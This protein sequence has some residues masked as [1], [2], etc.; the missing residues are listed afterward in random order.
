MFQAF[1][2]FRAV[3]VITFGIVAPVALFVAL[4]VSPG[5]AHAQAGNVY[6]SNQTQV[7]GGVEQ[8]VVLQVSIKQVE[9]SAQSRVAGGAIGA[10]VGGALAS[11]P[12]IDASKRVMANILGVA[13]G[14]LAGERIANASSGKE[15]QEMIIKLVDQQG[16][17]RLITVV[18]P[19]P[20]DPMFKGDKVFVSNTQ[21]AVRVIKDESSL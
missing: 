12:N 6:G 3:D 7:Y 17:A 10:A 15:A 2:T 1:K 11:N 14:G 19:E 4:F 20:F 16:R 13:L 9:A 21:G 8:G 18:Q 5:N